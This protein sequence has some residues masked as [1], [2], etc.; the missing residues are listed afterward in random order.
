MKEKTTT[1]SLASKRKN[2]HQADWWGFFII[3]VFLF[4]PEPL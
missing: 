3:L 4:R 2:P 1:V